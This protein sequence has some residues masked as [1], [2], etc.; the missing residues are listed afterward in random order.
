MTKI[1]THAQIH[2]FLSDTVYASKPGSL[3]II[4]LIFAL[5]ALTLFIPGQLAA[6][7]Q[8]LLFR[9]LYHYRLQQME[10][11]WINLLYWCGNKDNDPGWWLSDF[12]TANPGQFHA[13]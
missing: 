4:C 11:K 7:Y 9:C 13:V 5:F 10:S 2:S 1:A 8:L 12:Q 6:A 3:R